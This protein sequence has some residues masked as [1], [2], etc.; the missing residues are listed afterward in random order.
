MDFQWSVV[1]RTSDPPSS[2]CGPNCSCAVVKLLMGIRNGMVS[3]AS[4]SK[5][6]S[7]VE[8]VVYRVTPGVALTG[9]NSEL[10][11]GQSPVARVSFRLTTHKKKNA[12]I[13]AA[14]EPPQNIV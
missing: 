4:P 10:E 5:M 14:N 13:L 6:P 3:Y 9:T 7:H 8:F 11:R 1:A 12:P 2:C